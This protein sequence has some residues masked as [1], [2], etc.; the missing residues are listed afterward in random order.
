MASIDPVQLTPR[1]AT[2]LRHLLNRAF[3]PA[4]TISR[5]AVP[6]GSIR[7]R[8]R[9]G[10]PDEAG[11]GVIWGGAVTPTGGHHVSAAEYWTL[12]LPHRVWILGP[13]LEIDKANLGPEERHAVEQKILQAYRDR[14][15]RVPLSPEILSLIRRSVEDLPAW[16]DLAADQIMKSTSTSEANDRRLRLRLEA[17]R[18]GAAGL[19]DEDSVATAEVM[20]DILFLAHACGLDIDAAQRRAEIHSGFVSLAIRVADEREETAFERAIHLLPRTTIS[21]SRIPEAERAGVRQFTAERSPVWEH[22]L[23]SPSRERSQGVA[24][25]AT[26]QPQAVAREQPAVPPQRPARRTYAII[27]SRMAEAVVGH[28]DECR[29]LSLVGAAHLH[30]V[31][32]QRVLIV[33]TTGSGKTHVAQALA[34]ALERPF[35]H[36][37]AADLSA[38]G[39]KGLDVPDMLALLADQSPTGLDGAILHV[40][41][42]DKVRLDPGTDGNSRDAR[43]GMMNSLL[44]LLDGRP[45]TP[46]ASRDQLRTDGLLVIGSGAFEGRFVDRPPTTGDLI[47]WGWTAEVAARWSDRLVLPP[48]DRRGAVELLRRSERSIEERL[49]PLLQALGIEVRVPAEVLAYAA[50]RWLMYGSDFRT[51]A[52]WLLTAAKARL[53]EAIEA[54]STESIV[55]SPDDLAFGHPPQP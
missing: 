18:R 5:C 27:R 25:L 55:I 49:G 15:N 43:L 31:R 8:A 34:S 48:L 35:L 36:V 54:G 33:G 10:Q 32:G 24:D 51:A 4:Q 22:G 52:E 7:E 14:Y 30:G 37:D 6:G 20:S 29:Y 9:C 3:G 19:W 21:P 45:V 38:T 26:R 42:V 23:L 28:D 46:D 17:L 50:D 16:L 1:Y 12:A 40:D 2:D 53:I 47:R 11:A 44:A 39:W 13:L 41:E